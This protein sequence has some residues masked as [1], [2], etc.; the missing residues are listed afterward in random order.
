[1][2]Q[3]AFRDDDGSNPIQANDHSHEMSSTKWAR[4]V[5]GPEMSCLNIEGVSGWSALTA[6]AAVME[7]PRME[8]MLGLDPNPQFVEDLGLEADS[9]PLR[10]A[11]C[12]D[13]PIEEADAKAIEDALVSGGSLHQ[14]D[15]RTAASVLN[16]SGVIEIQSRTDQ[17]LLAVIAEMM[18]GYLSGII[19]CSPMEL[20]LPD[21]GMIDQLMSATGR[22]AIRPM[23]TDIY[24]EFVDLGLALPETEKFGPATT[25]IVFDRCSQTWHSE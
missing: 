2:N 25:S 13:G 22:L 8:V 21:P 11:V 17:P 4:L 14:A 15:I 23:E 3:N 16:Q 24:P 6:V 10:Y 12:V 7:S 9:P 5:H 19:S 18:R 20:P 1:M